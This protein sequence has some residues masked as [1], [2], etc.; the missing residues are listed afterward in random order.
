MFSP[1]V[2]LCIQLCSSIPNP[3]Y[4]EKISQ[5]T[6]LE[7][8]VMDDDVSKPELQ[9]HLILGA[10]EYSRIKTSTKPKLGQPVADL[11]PLDRP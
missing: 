2:I 10:S 3:M 11:P 5:Y 6:H 8:V 1:V 7:G 9:V 4:A